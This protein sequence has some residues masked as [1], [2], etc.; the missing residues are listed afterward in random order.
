[1]Q[2][3]HH[4]PSPFQKQIEGVPSAIFTRARTP[5][6]IY[7]AT[8]SIHADLGLYQP[9]YTPALPL[10]LISQTVYGYD[11][12]FAAG[13]MEEY[14][15]GFVDESRTAAI[16]N[17]LQ[18][19]LIRREG[20]RRMEQWGKEPISAIISGAMQELEARIRGWQW[21]SA[22]NIRFDDPNMQLAHGVALDWA[23]KLICTLAVEMELL[24]K[25]RDIY[26]SAFENKLLPWQSLNID[27]SVLYPPQ[28]VTTT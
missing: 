10:D 13:T 14:N 12:L 1:M 15:E 8:P 25:G 17:T 16:L 22:Q 11:Y 24:Q 4:I 6:K 26:K 21:Y 5:F 28:S 20:A 23:A 18:Y 2:H 9:P 27:I 7:S 19:R 3:A